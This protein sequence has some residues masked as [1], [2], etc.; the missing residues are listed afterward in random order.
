MP[1]GDTIEVLTSEL[2]S[3]EAKVSLGKT[4]LLSATTLI[5]P[6][7]GQ[8]SVGNYVPTSYVSKGALAEDP[9]QRFFMT[10]MGRRIPIP[11][12]SLN[13]FSVDS[14]ILAL[15]NIS[16]LRAE[17]AATTARLQIAMEQLESSKANMD[18]AY[19]QIVD[20]GIARESTRFARCGILV[21]AGGTILS[22]ANE[23]QS[24]AMQML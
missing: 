20:P 1:N 10:P 6:R 11:P 5:N 22:Q 21:Q 18:A 4:A 19:S 3:N 16:T 24:N 2:G 9:A 15:R 23:P 8:M 7:I 13:R 17:N 12:P 14:F